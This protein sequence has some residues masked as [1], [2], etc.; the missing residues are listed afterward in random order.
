[1]GRR[2]SAVVIPDA[3]AFAGIPIGFPKPIL[4]FRFH[5]TRKWRFD[6]AWPNR[7]VALELEGGIWSRGRHTR[8]LGFLEDM[9]K[10]NEAAAMNWLVLRYQTGGKGMFPLTHVDWDQVARALL[11]PNE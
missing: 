6:Y 7:K 10:Y 11:A 3:V 5:P 4:E 2:V 8:P 1:M 9:E